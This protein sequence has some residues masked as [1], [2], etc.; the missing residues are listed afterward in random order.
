VKFTLSVV[1]FI[2]RSYFHPPFPNFL[3]VNGR[4]CAILKF[5]L[6][7]FLELGIMVPD[8][9]VQ[10]SWLKVGPHNLWV[11]TSF[12]RA[13]LIIEDKV[14]GTPIKTTREANRLLQKERSAW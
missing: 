11:L 6:W 1:C 5:P 12:L 10:V 3:L 4:L 7:G 8:C 2:G 14:I 13:L 9:V